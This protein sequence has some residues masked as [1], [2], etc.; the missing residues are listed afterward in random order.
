MCVFLNFG[1]LDIFKKPE[2]IQFNQFFKH[3]PQ[4]PKL[5]EKTLLN[6]QKVLFRSNGS[7]QKWLTNNK[8]SKQLFYYFCLAAF[9][10]ESNNFIEGIDV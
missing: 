4:K 1:P 5:N 2:I 3:D 10:S 7:E 6:F 9:S 8:N